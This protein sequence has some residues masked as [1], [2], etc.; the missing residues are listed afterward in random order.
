MGSVSVYISRLHN[1]C[2]PYSTQLPLWVGLINRTRGGGC[3]LVY[4]YSSRRQL[5]K[6][7]EAQIT[8]SLFPLSVFFSSGLKHG[9]QR[10]RGRRRP[11]TD[12]AGVAAAQG[13]PGHGRISGEHA[14]DD[15]AMRRRK[16]ESDRATSTSFIWVISVPFG[17]G[18]WVIYMHYYL[19]QIC[20]PL[21]AF[22]QSKEAGIKTLVALDDQGGK[23][24]QVN[25]PCTTRARPSRQPPSRGGTFHTSQWPI[26]LKE[27][28]QI[29]CLRNVNRPS[30]VMRDRVSY[31]ISYVNPPQSLL[32]SCTLLPSS[33]IT[34][35][36]IISSVPFRFLEPSDGRENA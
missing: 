5:R 31:L 3:I 22:I 2:G 24:N 28:S 8:E 11:P 19:S 27:E 9:G 35:L 21:I 26:L 14:A 13:Q 33:P 30:S 4:F 12:G 10:R 15:H 23:C 32:I 20:P 36:R 29:P 25:P 17:I 7:L 1:A 6:T 16:F 18:W 34:S